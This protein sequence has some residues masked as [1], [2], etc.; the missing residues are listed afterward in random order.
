MRFY[1]RK[2]ELEELERVRKLCNRSTHFTILSGRR[3][4]G[5]T[6]LVKKF[7]EN[8]EHLYFFIGRKNPSLL[9]EELSEIART[10]IDG[11]PTILKFDEWLEFLLNNV[12]D[13]TVVFF[14]EF[15]NLKYVDESIFSDFQKVFD[16]HKD[17]THVHIIAAGSHITLMNK[18]FS[19]SKEPLF[20]RVTEKYV[21]KPLLFKDI[22]GML[23]EIGVTEIKEQIRWYT[24]FGGIPKYYVA[25][26][27]QGL[28]G[29]DIFSTLRLLIFREFAPLKEEARSILVEDF[30]SEHTSYFSILEA[31]A[32]GNSEMTTIANRSGIKV[33]SIAKY[34]SLLVKDFGYLDYV[35]PI[36]EQKPWKSKKGRYFISDNFFKFW[37]RY[38]YRNMSDYEIGNYDILIEKII[39]D[40]DSFTGRE[41]EKVATQFLME[42]N[43]QDT[44]PL[45]FSKIGKWWNRKGSEIDIIALDENTNDIL[46]CECKWRNRL[47]DVDVLEELMQ[48]SKFVDWNTGNRQEHFAVISR[49]GF[50]KKAGEF[51]KINGFLLYTLDD[52]GG[53]FGA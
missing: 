47:T 19:D 9:L 39:Q 10:K 46:F 43:K 38:V 37:F 30:G 42:M 15:Q 20:G 53:C 34:L 23:A 1:N 18:I 29:D 41:F 26:E 33:Q 36:T 31:I 52:V 51:A 7:C 17:K 48:K 45:K 2:D 5:K 40:F 11:F 8:K 24:V 28:F 6:E 3:R 21:L 13:N 16:D 49:S 12:G 14:D 27:E 4:V 22:A 25:A 50:S 32:L 44:L 35:V